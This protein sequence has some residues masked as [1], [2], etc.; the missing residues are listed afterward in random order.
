M[1]RL[2]L[3]LIM[4]SGF[5]YAETVD[6]GY[7]SR[8]DLKSEFSQDDSI[9]ENEIFIYLKTNNAAGD[10]KFDVAYPNIESFV[11]YDFSTFKRKK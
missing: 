4:V 10:V 8:P 1:K 7:F 6:Y 3:V 2:L 11:E 5:V 9:N